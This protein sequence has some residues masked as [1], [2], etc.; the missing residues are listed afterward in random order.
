M[1]TSADASPITPVHNGADV[2]VAMFV[3]FGRVVQSPIK[4]TQDKREFRFQFCSFCSE[5]VFLYCLAFSS[6]FEKYQSTQNI[7]ISEIQVYTRKIHT[8][9]NF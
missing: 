9:V 7:R 2:E 5:A 8:S 1:E 6:E 3:L 4:L